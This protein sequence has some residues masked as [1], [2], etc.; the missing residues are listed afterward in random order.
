M[1]SIANSSSQ[2]EEEDADYDDDIL[3][4]VVA[5][6]CC[7]YLLPLSFSYTQIQQNAINCA[8]KKQYSY[9]LNGHDPWLNVSS[10]YLIIPLLLLL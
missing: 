10:F 7:Y 8:N 9:T 2:K 4:A 1:L 3:P 6:I 5:C